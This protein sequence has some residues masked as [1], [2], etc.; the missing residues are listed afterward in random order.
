M[1]NKISEGLRKML[2]PQAAVDVELGYRNRDGLRIDP[3]GFHILASFIEQSELG[4]AF[5]AYRRKRVEELRAE[6]A[7][8]EANNKS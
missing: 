4:E 1:L 8:K 6:E 2:T 7:A 3:S 5:A